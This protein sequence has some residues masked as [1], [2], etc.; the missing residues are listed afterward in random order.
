MSLAKEFWSAT[1]DR[2]FK[3]ECHTS[4]VKSF[5]PDAKVWDY[6]PDAGPFGNND[7]DGSYSFYNTLTCVEFSDGSKVAFNYKGE[8]D[9]YL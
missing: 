2:D 3:R 9:E 8:G 7:S 6:L 5:D 1:A 4:L